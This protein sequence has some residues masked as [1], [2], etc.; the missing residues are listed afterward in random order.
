MADLMPCSPPDETCP[1]P[2]DDLGMKAHGRP[3]QIVSL[4][5]R[6]ETAGKAAGRGAA[7]GLAQMVVVCM[8][9]RSVRWMP[10]ARGLSSNSFVARSN[11]AARLAPA[12]P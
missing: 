10:N 4:Q 6:P 5:P 2:R 11:I 7:A 12:P 8:L 3:G 9:R 1:P